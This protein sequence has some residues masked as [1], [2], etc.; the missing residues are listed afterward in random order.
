MKLY[1]MYEPAPEGF[2]DLA[3]DNSRPRFQD[4]RKTKLTLQAINKLRKMSE[5]EHYEHAT[6]L[7]K[8]R[9]QYSPAA[10]PGGLA[11]L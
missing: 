4:N 2:Q 3:D 7:K 5:V 6:N 9:K 8:V 10:Q 11:G 1:E